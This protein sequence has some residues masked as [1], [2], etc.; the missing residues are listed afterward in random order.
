MHEGQIHQ[1]SLRTHNRDEAVRRESVLHTELLRGEFGI[2]SAKGT[3]NLV[4]F[5]PRLLAHWKQNVSPRTY[6]YY[7]QNL[8]TLSNCSFLALTRLHKIDEALIEKFIQRRLKDEVS[9]TTVNHAL[10]TLRCA[11]GIACDWKLIGRKPKVKLLTG[12]HERDYVISEQLVNQMAD[13]LRENCARGVFHLM[14]PFMCDT[15]LRVSEACNLKKEHITFKDGLPVSIHVAKGK[16]KAAKRDIPLS[17]RASLTL[18]AALVESKC[19][20]AFTGQYGTHGLTRLYPSAQFLKVK[21][22]L[23]IT[24]PDCVLHSTRHTF[25]TRLGN[26]GADAFTIKALAGHSSITISQRYVHSNLDAKQRA[27]AIID[28][29]NNPPVPA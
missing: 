4:E 15:G 1:Q 25:C 24:D 16:S 19:D 13:W 10:R 6:A 22:A 3:P 11:L 8:A 26:K 29:L 28:A 17:E 23:G 5:T 18:A 9:V 2:I 27:I 21:R 20:Y 7:E 14:L 12:E